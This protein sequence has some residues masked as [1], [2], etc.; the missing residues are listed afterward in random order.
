MFTEPDV[1]LYAV[2]GVVRG[3]DPTSVD[4]Y[5]PATN[6]WRSDVAPL[7]APREHVAGAAFDGR[8]WL[9]AGRWAG[10]LATVASYDPAT[11]AWASA[12]NLPLPR[13]GLTA[14]VLDGRIHV[15][16]GESVSGTFSEHEVFDP[17]AGTW[18]LW[19]DLPNHRHGL[20]SGVV[21]NDW[22]V[23]GGGRSPN[24]SV[25]DVVDIFRDGP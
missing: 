19:P 24:L 16:G 1:R 23:A 22:I 11:D 20:A 25:S 5:D 13:G 6:A 8:V 15:T 17:G 14:A 12:P 3:A 10:D 7:P 4:V 9:I 2:G 21:G 18:S